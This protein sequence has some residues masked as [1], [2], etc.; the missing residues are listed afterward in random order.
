MRTSG[1]VRQRV[2]EN[3]SRSIEASEQRAIAARAGEPRKPR[4]ALEAM[5][6]RL[7]VT[8]QKLQASLTE[9]VFRG[10]R[11]EAEFIAL[12]IVANSYNLNPLTKEIYAFPA[13]GGGIVPMISVDGWIKIMN[14]HPQFDGIEFEYTL[15]DKGGVTAIESII[16]RK[17]RQ[18]PIKTIEFMEECRRGT[19]PWKLMP[20]RM[21]RNRSL[22]QGVRIAFGIAAHAEGDEDAI[23]GS[24]RDAPVRSLPSRQTLADE[25]DDEIPEFRANPETGEL[26]EQ[27]D[28]RGMTEVSEDEARA[29]D[30]GEGF[31]EQGGEESQGGPAEEQD[32]EPVY[33]QT[34]RELRGKISKTTDLKA[35]DGLETEWLNRVR[36]GVS[37][38][39]LVREVEKQIVAKRK[40]LKGKEA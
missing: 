24:Y 39:E 23:E 13:K 21:L 35:L 3:E 7:E 26:V 18:H 31:D 2:H 22:I 28:E 19:D 14:S 37:D 25:F 1:A 40:Y 9:T 34:V 36:G 4:N 16:H 38:E 32:E 5:A 11:S 12:V 6:T 30:A 33:L 10:C 17:D 15:D 20:R 8:P 27:R 29:L